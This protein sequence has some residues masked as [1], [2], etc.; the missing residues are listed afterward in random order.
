MNLAKQLNEFDVSFDL[1]ED[2]VC[3][4]ACGDDEEGKLVEECAKFEEE[5]LE[6]CKAY[7]DYHPGDRR[8]GLVV[9]VKFEDEKAWY[10]ENSECAWISSLG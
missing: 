2:G 9:W 5:V 3:L 8:A 10:D 6:K 7:V 4:A 1:S